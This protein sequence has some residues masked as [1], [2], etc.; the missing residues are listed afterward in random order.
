MGILDDSFLLDES[1][2]E[3]QLF[4]LDGD[5]LLEVTLGQPGS[6]VQQLGKVDALLLQGLD[7]LVQ[8]CRQVPRVL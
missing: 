1:I 2:L 3:G 7:L 8:L 6:L 5:E 4:L